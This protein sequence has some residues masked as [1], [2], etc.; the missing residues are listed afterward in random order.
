MSI[1]VTLTYDGKEGLGSFNTYQLDGRKHLRNLIVDSEYFMKR[2][3]ADGFS[4]YQCE[5]LGY[6]EKILWTQQYI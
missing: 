3:K 4:I 1:Y 6:N 2:E 5:H